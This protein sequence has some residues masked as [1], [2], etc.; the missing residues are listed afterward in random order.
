MHQ[1]CIFKNLFVFSSV[2]AFKCRFEF[3]LAPAG[4]AKWGGLK[5][6]PTP[7]KAHN[8]IEVEAFKPVYS[9]NFNYESNF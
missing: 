3:N 8:W 2:L 9:G 1:T 7:F 6:F 5:A 4:F